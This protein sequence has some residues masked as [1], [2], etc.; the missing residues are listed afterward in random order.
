MLIAMYN[1]GAKLFSSIPVKDASSSSPLKSKSQS[2]ESIASSKL[3]FDLKF[4]FQ[5]GQCK[6]NSSKLQY[7]SRINS[8]NKKGLSDRSEEYRDQLFF[9]PGIGIIVDGSM[10]FGPRDDQS[11]PQHI[12]IIQTVSRIL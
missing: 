3:A 9:L 11:E 10:L 2:S 5:A 1:H 12:N 6:F 4:D 7:N 8:K